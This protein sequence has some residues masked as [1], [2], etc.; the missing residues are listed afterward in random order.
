MTLPIPK[1]TQD[2][3]CLRAQSLQYQL[4][5]R[6]DAVS[7]GINGGINPSVVLQLWGAVLDVLFHERDTT[8]ECRMCRSQELERL[9]QMGLDTHIAEHSQEFW[10]E[11][12]VELLKR[13]YKTKKQVEAYV[14]H[15]H[16]SANLFERFYK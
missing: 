14:L 6:L 11:Y 3:V 8:R 2:F 9:V 16:P 7:T 12:S 13:V 15:S 1:N 5:I 10:S 4:G